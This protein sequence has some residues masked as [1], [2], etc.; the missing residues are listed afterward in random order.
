MTTSAELDRPAGPS[1]TA[2]LHADAIVSAATSTD[3]PLA[4]LMACPD[5]W[6]AHLRDAPE[7]RLLLTAH[8]D[9]GTG[10]ILTSLAR[11]D[12]SLLAAHLSVPDWPRDQHRFFMFAGGK[13]RT[14][15]IQECARAITLANRGCRRTWTYPAGPDG[16]IT[17]DRHI[18][19]APEHAPP[20]QD[21]RE[22]H[23]WQ[24][25]EPDGSTRCAHCRAL[26]RE[27]TGAEGQVL[28]AVIHLPM[29]R[30]AHYLGQEDRTVIPV[31]SD[32]FH[33]A[34][35]LRITQAG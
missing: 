35:S 29:R 22:M 26:L 6:Q 10:D 7:G 31:T 13:A 17:I 15:E 28:R 14:V 5:D 24:T 16:R 27:E 9:I 4:A 20:F 32:E 3:A 30:R 34:P 21:M 2:I 8:F 1:T 25:P 18:P 12:R 19:L 11:P 33:G 23:S